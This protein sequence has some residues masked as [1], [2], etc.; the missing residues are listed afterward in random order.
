MPKR[1]GEE[2]VFINDEEFIRGTCPMT[3]KDIRILTIS[4]LNLEETSNVLDI[5]SGTGS[6][7]VQCAKIANKGMVYAVEK[8]DEAFNV[9][10]SN[11]EKFECNNVKVS[12][13]EAK[14]YLENLLEESENKATFDSIFIGGSGGNLEELIFLSDKLLKTKGTL[15]MNF[16]TL[17]NAYKG[18]EFIKTLNYSVD[19]SLVNISNNRG[20][21]YMMIAKN[22]IF[23]IECRRKEVK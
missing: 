22:P 20:E 12:K 21:T 1:E 2:M 15:V 10:N 13:C 6:V 3:K 5:G 18:I 14:K 19:I 16:I 9:T 17:D 8:D 4:K 11:V 23:I 7:T